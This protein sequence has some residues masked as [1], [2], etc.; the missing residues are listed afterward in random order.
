MGH[1]PDIVSET[2]ALL[3]QKSTG[4]DGSEAMDLE[5]DLSISQL[6]GDGSSRSFYRILR[7]SRPFG[8]AVYPSATDAK[9]MAEY[10]ASCRIGRHLEGAGLPV[11]RILAA[12]DRIGLVIFEDLGDTRLHDYLLQDRQKGLELY[13]EI[14]RLLARLQSEGIRGFQAMWCH[15]T[16]EYDREVMLEKESGYFYHTFWRGTL[17]G[18]EIP[19]LQE[20]FSTLAQ[21]AERHFQPLFLHRDFQSRNLMLSDGRIRII[22]Y[23]G[24]RLG[25]PAYDLASL[26]IDPY[27]GLTAEEQASLLD[28][29]CTELRHYPEIDAEEVRLSFPYLALQRNLQIIGAF[30]FL[31]GSRQKTFFRHYIRPALIA[32]DTRLDDPLFI[33]FRILKHIARQ[34]LGKYREK[35]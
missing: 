34:A 35:M 20:E 27:A 11:P 22:D 31:S 29:Y 30:A 14:I 28:L 4:P 33:E 21:T 26:L 15:D 3:L 16:Q 10:R 13:P 32:L 25:P 17:A 2:I 23:Q 6:S 7:N 24:G 5:Q 19:G 1:I 18:G 9:G 8:V 12:E